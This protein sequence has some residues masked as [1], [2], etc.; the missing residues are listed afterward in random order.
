MFRREWNCKQ[1]ETCPIL[2][3]VNSLIIFYYTNFI[4]HSTENFYLT[5]LN[6]F[7]HTTKFF[8]HMQLKIFSHRTKIFFLPD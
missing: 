4:K 6:F 8:S 1:D 2:R 5:Q 7:S 3:I